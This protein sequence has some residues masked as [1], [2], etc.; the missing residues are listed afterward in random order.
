MLVKV[1]VAVI[2][3]AAIFASGFGTEPLPDLILGAR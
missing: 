1:A 2:L 3:V